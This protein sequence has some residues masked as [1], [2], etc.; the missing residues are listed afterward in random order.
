M[1]KEISEVP[2][3][4]RQKNEKQ[5]IAFSF[6]ILML[7]AFILPSITDETKRCCIETVTDFNVKN[8]ANIPLRMY[9]SFNREFVLVDLFNRTTSPQLDFTFQHSSHVTQLAWHA[10]LQLM[11][12]VRFRTDSRRT[13]EKRYLRPV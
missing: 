10:P 7:L 1:K 3:K 13:L 6:D 2:V 9:G 5:L 4:K 12:W 8:D 11:V